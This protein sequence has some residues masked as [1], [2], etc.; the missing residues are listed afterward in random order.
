M[1]QMDTQDA[2]ESA[3]SQQSAP[4]EKLDV[5]SVNCGSRFWAVSPMQVSHKKRL[6]A[7]PESHGSYDT[8]STTTKNLGCTCGR[9]QDSQPMNRERLLALH[10]EICGRA[11][12]LMKRKNAD[13][14]G[15]HDT[16]NP[17]LNFTRCEAM[18]ITTTERGFLVRLTDKMSR[19]ST[20]CDTGS[21][22]VADEKLEDT[23]EDIINY[24]ILFLAFV[25]SNNSAQRS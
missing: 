16:K 13:Y 19:L 8:A 17:F 18:G 5:Q 22:Q 24:S 15:G 7:K 3:P 6:Y 11:Y 10:T 12:E 14:S 2:R 23:V 20:F 25:R 1:Q 21:F 9:P 4:S